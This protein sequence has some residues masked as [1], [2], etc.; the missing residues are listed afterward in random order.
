[1]VKYQLTKELLR[2]YFS[3]YYDQLRTGNDRINPS[4]F[5]KIKETEF[6]LILKKIDNQS[7]KFT[8]LKEII[9]PS[10]RKVFIP[11]IRDRLV[12]EYLKDRIKQKYHINFPNRDDIIK[13]IQ[14]KFNFEMDFYI[15]RLDIKH[16]F[17]S[18]PNNILLS[19]IK[20]KSLLSSHEYFILKELFRKSHRGLP[21]G[22]S[23]S[24]VLSEIYL[25]HFDQDLKQIHNRLNYYCRYVDDILL[26]I[27]GKLT[28]S[29]INLIQKKIAT[30]FKRYHLKINESKF[31]FTLFPLL[32]PKKDDKYG[33]DFLGYRFTIENKKLSYS[34]TKEKI[35][36]YIEKI[37]FC[38]V[39]F[40]KN[41]NMEL[42]IH[43]LDFLTKKNAIIKKEQFISR[44]KE[45]GYRKKKICYGFMENYNLISENERIRISKYIDELLKSEINSIK[46]ILNSYKFNISNKSKHRLFSISLSKN[47]NIY[48]AIYRYKKED[49]IKKLIDINPMYTFNELKNYSYKELSKM[50]FKFLRSDML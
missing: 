32:N 10:H 15:I 7:Y 26:I 12:I 22:V 48:N 18:I 47:M 13:T 4:N 35:R 11:T 45:I 43:R 19:K 40:K 1:M 3:T 31:S 34:I 5:N 41:R 38:F 6:N 44:N 17:D 42:L 50:Y 27:N 49:Y 9:L 25:E 29:E 39:D 23:V 28:Q 33:F 14:L 2:N 20:E 21:Q 30:I 46:F 16:F 8:D 24:N 36:K 37:K